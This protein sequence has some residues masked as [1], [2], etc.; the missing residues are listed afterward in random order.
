M[1]LFRLRDRVLSCI[2]EVYLKRKSWDSLEPSGEPNLENELKRYGFSLK[3]LE[4]LAALEGGAQVSDAGFARCG[5]LG[6]LG[7]RC[8]WKPLQP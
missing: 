4:D 7:A 8:T 1:W 2:L 5:P 6:Q 3:D